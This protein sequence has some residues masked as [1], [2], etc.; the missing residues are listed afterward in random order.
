MVRSFPKH[1]VNPLG[2]YQEWTST[3]F[4]CK[5]SRPDCNT[6]LVDT[7]L[8]DGLEALTWQVG[9][10][11]VLSGYRCAAH[12]ADVGGEPHSQHLLGKAAD[13]QSL[14]ATPTKVVTAAED[15][16]CFKNGGVGSYL[17]FTHLDVRGSRVRWTITK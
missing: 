12:N 4:D 7:D 13:V 10:P 3:D 6:T 16:P 11:R 1:S 5:C 15:I 17:T 9:K 8:V 14:L 2:E